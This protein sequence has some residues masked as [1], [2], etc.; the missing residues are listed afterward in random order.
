MTCASRGSAA[1]APPSAA[2]V[3]QPAITAVVPIKQQLRQ[4][5]Q[6]VVAESLGGGIIYLESG[7]LLKRNA[8]V[9]HKFRPHSNFAYVAGYC[10]PGAGCILDTESGQPR[11]F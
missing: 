6:R 2:N 11:C 10:E 8:D 9:F 3:A 1:L 7:E 5:Q 4:I